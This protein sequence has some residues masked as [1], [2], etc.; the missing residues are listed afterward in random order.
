MVSDVI[1][2]RATIWTSTYDLTNRT[3]VIRYWEDKY[4]E[5]RLCF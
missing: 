1:G 3:M 4:K 5:H 2:T